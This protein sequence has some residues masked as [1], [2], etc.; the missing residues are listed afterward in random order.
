MAGV[1]QHD[2]DKD[3]RRGLPID[4]FVT[5]IDPGETREED[6]K[7]DVIA[8]VEPVGRDEF[9]AAGTRDMKAKYKLLVWENEYREES[10]VVFNDR[11]LFIYRTYG[12]RP[13]GKV[14][15]YTGERVGVR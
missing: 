2:S 13:D 8:A 9:V 11:R 1:L 15:L 6:I 5:L 3:Q 14:E 10:E 7:R 12:P 4:A